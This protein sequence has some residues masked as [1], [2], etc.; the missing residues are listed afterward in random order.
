MT[1]GGG[2]A[3]SDVCMTALPRRS[4]PFQVLSHASVITKQEGWSYSCRGY[5]GPTT[6]TWMMPSQ[7]SVAIDD[8]TGPWEDDTI[9]LQ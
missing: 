6:L 3:L 1:G 5:R 4:P 7:V 2:Q 9:I 8:Q